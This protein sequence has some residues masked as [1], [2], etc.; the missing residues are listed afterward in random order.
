VLCNYVNVSQEETAWDMAWWQC[1]II[2][3]HCI[4]VWVLNR[5]KNGSYWD[6]HIKEIQC[7]KCWIFVTW[8][9]GLQRKEN[10]TDCSWNAFSLTDFF[11]HCFLHCISKIQCAKEDKQLF[12]HIPHSFSSFSDKNQIKWCLSL[13]MQYRVEHVLTVKIVSR[14]S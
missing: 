6:H 5:I 14:F 10:T 7:V 12:G 11:L 9:G 13:K 4:N 8:Q 2:V 1:C 3:S